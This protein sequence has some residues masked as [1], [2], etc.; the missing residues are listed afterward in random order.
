VTA[1]TTFGNY[2]S[3]GLQ[4]VLLG[5]RYG[6]VQGRSAVALQ[7][8]WQAPL[9][10]SRHTSL[11]GD[12][13]QQ[14]SLSALVGTGLGRFGFVQGGAGMGYRFLSFDQGVQTAINQAFWSGQSGT[15]LPEDQLAEQWSRPIVASADLGLWI[16]PSLLLGGRYAGSMASSSGEGFPERTVH[17]AGPLLLWRVDERLDLSAGSWST[18]LAKNALHYDQ[19]YVTLTFKQTRL[20]RLQGFL[21]GNKAP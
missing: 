14:F 8:D 12:G 9:G 18:A 15:L 20:N 17:L 21:G 2:T 16:R 7:L 3:T 1:R 19:V 11:L 5:V 13:L 4:D 10:Y 6:L